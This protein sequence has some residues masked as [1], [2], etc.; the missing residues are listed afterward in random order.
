VEAEGTPEPVRRLK[1]RIQ[2]SDAIMIATPEY[3]YS[4]PGVLKNALDW[5]SRPPRENPFAGKPAGIIGAGGARGTIRAQ[6]H[7]RYICVELNMHVLNKPEIMI[8]R[9]WEKFDQNGN[10]TDERTLDQLRAFMLEFK[11]WI[12]RF[13]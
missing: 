13:K 3:N 7:L 6:A 8:E 1:E 11:L 12:S 2:A 9:P 4:V 5:A 10:L